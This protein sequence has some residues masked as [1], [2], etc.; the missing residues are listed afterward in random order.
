VNHPL[1][2]RDILIGTYVGESFPNRPS[3]E[4][5]SGQIDRAI[6]E[7]DF[8]KRRY[9]E[10]IKE[11]AE[12]WNRGDATS[13]EYNHREQDYHARRI[14]DFAANGWRDAPTLKM[15]GRS[16]DDGLHRLKA[17]KH[18]GKKTVKVRIMCPDAAGCKLPTPL[19]DSLIAPKGQRLRRRPG[20]RKRK[21][22][23]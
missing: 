2:S 13:Q 9:Q 20:A 12:E 4:P 11:L 17:A 23:R 10:H 3:C 7:K 22:E 5:T 8:D 16:V 6:R 14:A 15:D 19:A 21:Q 1:V 18:L